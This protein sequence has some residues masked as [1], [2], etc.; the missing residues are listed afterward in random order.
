MQSINQHT[1]GRE[2][3]FSKNERILML[4]NL[5]SKAVNTHRHT[6]PYRG[7]GVDGVE[8]YEDEKGNKSLGYLYSAKSHPPCPARRP[9]QAQISIECIRVH[10]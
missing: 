8:I 5:T 10:S 3:I 9:V 1:A 4:M 6:E 2:F 7:E